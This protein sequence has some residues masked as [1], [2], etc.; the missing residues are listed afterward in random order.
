ML[1]VIIRIKGQIDPSWSEW[2][3]DLDI[4]HAGG[5]ETT[6]KGVIQDQSELY[7]LLARLWNLRLELISVEVD[8]GPADQ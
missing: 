6:L 5:D 3:Q 7:G 4:S 8:E 1:S 2:F